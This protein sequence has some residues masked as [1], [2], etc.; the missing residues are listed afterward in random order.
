MGTKIKEHESSS[1]GCVDYHVNDNEPF[2]DCPTSSEEGDP[3][4]RVTEPAEDVPVF[5][6]L[7][8]L[9]KLMSSINNSAG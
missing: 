9:S 5:D 1:S 8:E 3:N 2:Y 6:H 4:K 7:A